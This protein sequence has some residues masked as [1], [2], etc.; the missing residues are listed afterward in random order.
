MIFDG[1]AFAR[2]IEEQLV[3]KVRNFAKKPRIV[4]ILVGDDPASALYTR[5]KKQAAE[6][7]GIEFDVQHLDKDQL[8]DHI[9]QISENYDGVMIQLPI[10]GLQG[11]ALQ[12]VLS[13][14]PLEKDV[15]GLRWEESGIMPATVRAVLSLVDEI[16]KDKTIF[17]VLGSRGAVGRPL[18]YFLKERRSEV[19]E[20]EFDT[21]K[22]E[23]LTRG[24]EV[25]ISCVGKAGLVTD[26]MVRDGMI[27]I[28]VG[29]S[30]VDGKVV[31][32]MTQEVYQKA[33]VAVP[34]PGGVGPVTIASLMANAIDVC[35]MNKI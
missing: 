16:A 31:G 35:Q 1:K 3:Y 15:D 13:A 10:A 30:E 27:V 5:L 28:D 18:V 22:P 6:R 12:E 4:S 8:V 32:D 29:M 17:A 14:I 33:S 34:V 23:E 2:R 24:A 25:V 26:E 11:H 20:I 19:T 7:V 9:T 21:K